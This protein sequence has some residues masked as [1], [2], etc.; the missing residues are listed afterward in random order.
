MVT[1]PCNLIITVKLVRAGSRMFRYETQGFVQ[2]DGV[3]SE[4]RAFEAT[5]LGVL[6]G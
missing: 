4:K 1:P 2:K 5:V 6:I 3:V